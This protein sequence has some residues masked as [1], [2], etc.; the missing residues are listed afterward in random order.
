MR[1]VQSLL[2]HRSILEQFQTTNLTNGMDPLSYNLKWCQ[3][4]PRAYNRMAVIW[5]LNRH[6]WRKWRSAG[7][8]R[9]ERYLNRMKANCWARTPLWSLAIKTCSALSSKLPQLIRIYAEGPLSAMNLQISKKKKPLQRILQWEMIRLL[10]PVL[11]PCL[12]HSVTIALAQLTQIRSSSSS[13]RSRQWQQ[14]RQ[15]LNN[16]RSVNRRVWGHRAPTKAQLSNW[17]STQIRANRIRS[18][19][20]TQKYSNLSPR[21]AVVHQ[22]NS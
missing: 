13:V 21:R 20:R 5:L 2:R 9:I 10:R 22:A 7:S 6:R 17:M 18:I 12:R 11:A 15:S 3:L 14:T 8:K 16:G 4:F 19:Q 1:Q